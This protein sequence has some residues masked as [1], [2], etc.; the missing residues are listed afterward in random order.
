[1]S[2]KDAKLSYFSNLVNTQQ[3]DMIAVLVSDVTTIYKP[4]F[5]GPCLLPAV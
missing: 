1:M 2:V 3:T 5:R 4:S